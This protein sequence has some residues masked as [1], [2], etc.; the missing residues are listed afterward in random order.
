[1]TALKFGLAAG[2][3]A[4]LTTTAMAQQAPEAG[5]EEAPKPF[6]A[7]EPL[8]AVNE[9]GDVIIDSVNTH[10]CRGSERKIRHDLLNFHYFLPGEFIIAQMAVA[11][12]NHQVRKHM[13]GA[14]HRGLLSEQGS[15]GVVGDRYLSPVAHTGKMGVGAGEAGHPDAFHLGAELGGRL[16]LVDGHADGVGHGVGDDEFLHTGCF[17]G[18]NDDETFL[19]GGMTGLQNQ[20]VL[21]DEFEDLLQFRDGFAVAD[22]GD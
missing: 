11:T 6:A 5:A 17:G 13:L 12:R 7:G 8:G 2:A 15:F 19:G 22:N 4:L 18:A 16:H 1:M 21:G 20:V 9:A 14:R 10:S 3:F